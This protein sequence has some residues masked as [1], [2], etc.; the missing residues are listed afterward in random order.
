MAA[1]GSTV[2][3]KTER[4]DKS[5]FY[6]SLNNFLRKNRIFFIVLIAIILAGVLV[7]AIWTLVDSKTS[8]NSAKA[9]EQV[10]TSIQ[11]WNAM[12][13]GPEAQS[14][15]DTILAEL[16]TLASKYGRRY[17]SQKA[18]VLAGRIYADREDWSNAEKKFKQAADL[19]A[20]SFLASFALQEAAVAAEEQKNNET[21]IALWNRVIES[22]S[23]SA[24]GLPHAYFDLG[25]LYEESKQYTEASVRYEKLIATYPDNDWTKLARDRII[26]LKSQG[27]LP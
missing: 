4:E 5:S 2:P 19:N 26:L 11:K 17:V 25:T 14:Q 7:A 20:D 21:A 16:D 6:A 22:K 18:Y 3:N 12:G 9:L 23:A 24:I 27:L 13:K 10:E 1:K 8:A 15:A